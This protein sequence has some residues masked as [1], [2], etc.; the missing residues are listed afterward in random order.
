MRYLVD[1]EE[2]VLVRRGPDHI[3]RY[4]EGPGEHRGIPQQISAGDL[5]GHDTQ[6]HIFSQRF[7]PAELENLSAR[8]AID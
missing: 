4:E 7:W 8:V 2:E 1:G 5:E 6:D 3:C